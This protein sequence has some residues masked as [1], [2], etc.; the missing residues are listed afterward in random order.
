MSAIINGANLEVNY[1]VEKEKTEVP[2]H[3][4]QNRKREVF[5][6]FL[7]LQKVAKEYVQYFVDKTE[8]FQPKCSQEGFGSLL[9]ISEYQSSSN[10]FHI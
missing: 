7:N 9:E 8:C 5:Y 6:T 4:L 3:H 1:A 10:S 2:E